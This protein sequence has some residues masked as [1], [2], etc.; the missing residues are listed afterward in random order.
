[1]AVRKTTKK[2]IV[3]EQVQEQEQ[4]IENPLDKYVFMDKAKEILD[5]GLKTNKNV[6]LY[7]PGGYGKSELTLDF[8]LYKGIAPYIMTMGSGTTMD[9]LMGGL[10]IKEYDLSG[11]LNYLCDNSFM[12]HEYVIFE[13]MM[14]APDYILESLKD[15]LSSGV[16]RNGTQFYPIKTKWIVC[17][18]N[19]SRADFAKNDSLK[20]LMERFPLELNV[21][22]DNYTDTAYTTL[23]EA[24][25]G[26]GNIEPI[27]PF[28]LQE[29]AKKG[30]TISPRIALDAFELFMECG[31]DSLGFL[32]DF[33]KDPSVITSALKSFE[34]T[35]KFKQ[36]GSEIE[37]LIK[38]LIANNVKSQA[39]KNLFKEQYDSLNT[40]YQEMRKLTVND[41]LAQIH[42]A[43]VKKA[44]ESISNLNIKY[45]SLNSPEAEQK[46]ATRAK[47]NYEDVEIESNP[48]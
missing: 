29:Y 27:I 10:D 18:T 21:I 25:W 1:M 14:D 42:A 20:A 48:F 2:E 22:W 5:V 6:I 44:S 37:E 32:A 35:M 43:L 7:G 4:V 38:E 16:F 9:K 28:I 34:G 19:K 11:K 41:D 31:P 8:L 36:T 33:A 13:E 17:C 23:L 12:N 15:I 39:N 46:R 45:I 30:K 26:K 3:K 47:K 24:R 40:K